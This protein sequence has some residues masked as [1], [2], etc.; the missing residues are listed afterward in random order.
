MAASTSAP[1]PTDAAA[2]SRPFA[3]VRPTV[4]GQ[5]KLE[6]KYPKLEGRVEADV[7]VVGGIGGLC[8]AYNLVRRGLK[9]VV[10]EKNVI[11]EC[12]GPYS[13]HTPTT[14]LPHS[15]H[16]SHLTLPHTLSY[17][18]FSPTLTSTLFPTLCSHTGQLVFTLR[19]PCPHSPPPPLP[20][21]PCPA[22]PC[23]LLCCTGSGQT[24]KTTAHLMAWN[25]DYYSVLEKDFGRTEAALIGQSHREAIDWVERTAKEEGIECE[26]SRLP[27]YLV[28][29]DSSLGTRQKVEKVCVQQ[30]CSL[31]AGR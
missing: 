26:F 13:Y 2:P 27:G 16:H 20:S 4:W 22:L 3:G 17:T 21:L 25:D 5:D 7:A 19:Q 12:W 14:L 11:G 10:L 9:V 15:L 1:M 30:G 6:Q 28:P 29:H 24:G 23:P 18:P 8:V 31:H